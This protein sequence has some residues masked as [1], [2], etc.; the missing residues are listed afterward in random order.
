[1]GSL[2]V[3]FVTESVRDEKSS[4]KTAVEMQFATLSLKQQ[5]SFTE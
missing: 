4:T 3:L 5:R 2:R 1:M